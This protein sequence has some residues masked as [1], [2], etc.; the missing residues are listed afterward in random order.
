MLSEVSRSILLKGYMS[1]AIGGQRTGDAD[2]AQGVVGYKVNCGFRSVQHFPLL[3][4]E[5]ARTHLIQ[6]A[7]FTRFLGIE[8]VQTVEPCELKQLLREEEPGDEERL[9]AEE[10]EVPI[11]DRLHVWR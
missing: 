1:N 7:T 4:R 3:W 6:L 5:E 2:V 9:G 10:G 8:L 11:V